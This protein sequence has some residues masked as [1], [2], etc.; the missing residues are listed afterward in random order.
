MSEFRINGTSGIDTASGA[1]GSPKKTLG[2]IDPADANALT[3]VSGDVVII[4]AGSGVYLGQ[5][6]QNIPAGVTV[7]TETGTLPNDRPL[8][9]GDLQFDYGAGKDTFG[10]TMNGV[11]IIG[12]RFRRFRKGGVGFGVGDSSNNLLQSLKIFE[13]WNGALDSATPAG[14]GAGL[15]LVNDSGST[16]NRAT[17]CVVED[18]YGDGIFL[19]T[20]TGTQ[21]WQVDHNTVRRCGRLAWLERGL[22]DAAGDGIADHSGCIGERFNNWI[23][24]VYNKGLSHR[25]TGKATIYNNFIRNVRQKALLC[26]TGQADFF[27]NIVVIL[28][29]DPNDPLLLNTPVGL[30]IEPALTTVINLVNNTFAN[31]FDGQTFTIMGGIGANYAISS[32]GNI[33]YGNGELIT[34]FRQSAGVPAF[35]P[36]DYNLYDGDGSRAFSYAPGDTFVNFQTWK[37]TL[38][39]L[40]VDRASIVGA[41][42]LPISADLFTHP[43]DA[44]IGAQS[45]AR[46][47]AREQ[48][49]LV[50][51]SGLASDYLGRTRP[52]SANWTAG[53][54]QYE[55]PTTANQ[56][57]T[58]LGSYTTP[59]E[60]NITLRRSDT[61]AFRLTLTGLGANWPELTRD[62]VFT[63]RHPVEQDPIR[64]VLSRTYEAEEVVVD[65]TTETAI[66]VLAPQVDLRAGQQYFYSWLVE[67]ANGEK[68]TVSHGKI[69]VTE[70]AVA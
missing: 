29:R 17:D 67:E 69:T 63:I 31:Y 24:D 37:D 54:I 53:A 42:G 1:P 11:S 32:L 3:L 8:I 51:H 36:W 19:T 10:D 13:I 7:M 9:D 26:A 60:K 25:G 12:L 4:E 35:G 61:A 23:E 41:S 47:V 45:D 39:V 15:V 48:I 65:G 6:L 28:P 5:H 62:V 58:M 43:L 21:D 22:N 57:L 27:N 52:L 33:F 38:A 64:P 40:L 20:F 68:T 70:N 49:V 2:V 46:G 59:V 44:D 34:H 16:G 56:T 55:T 14:E 30:A 66:T 50:P 18:I